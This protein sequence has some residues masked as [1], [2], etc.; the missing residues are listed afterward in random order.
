MKYVNKAFSAIKNFYLPTDK[1]EHHR[2]KLTIARIFLTLLTATLILVATYFAPM[3]KA[4]A[5]NAGASSQVA[6]DKEI[7]IHFSAPVKR[8]EITATITPEVKGEWVWS[9]DLFG[10]KRMYK[11]LV[12]KPIE[13]Y[14]LST[15][16]VVEVKGV[17]RV[18]GVGGARDYATEFQTQ[19]APQISSVGPNDGSV[20]VRPDAKIVINLDLPNTNIVEYT[21]KFEPAFDFTSNYNKEKTTLTLSPKSALVQGQ[22]YTL[23]VSR[24]AIAYDLAA[25][26]VILRGEPETVKTATFTVAMPP[27]VASYSPSGGYIPISTRQMRMAFTHDMDRT[28][29]GQNFVTEPALTGKISWENDKTLIFT[30]TNNLAYATTYRF[31]VKQGAKN[32]SGGFL[33]NDSVASFATIGNAYVTYFSPSN[34]SYGNRVGTAIEVGFDQAVD[35]TSAQ[36]KFSFSGGNGG[37]FA[38]NGNVMV[39]YPAG[40]LAK[41]SSYTISVATGVKSISGLDTNRGF[42]ATFYTEESSVKLAIPLDYQDRALSCE[43]AS[44]KMALN[45]KGAGV[46][47]GSILARLA[48]NSAPRINNVWGNPYA[49][50]VG[51]IDGAQNTTGYGVYWGPIASAGAA[52]RPTQAVVGLTAAQMASELAAGNPIVTWGTAGRAYYDPWYTSSGQKIDAWKGEH[53]RTVIG[54][55]G[56]VWAPRQF[57]VNDPIFGQKYWSTD[58]LLGNMSAFG[59]AGVIVR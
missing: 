47:E 36:S 7:S 23:T 11:T 41:D 5:V 15:K 6:I 19:R 33:P 39:Y 25:Q 50:F 35:H 22:K 13:A 12:F 53:A 58:A 8:D 2:V 29:V 16:Y 30:Y 20:E 48:Y 31:I 21:A 34:G 40:V 54:F 42:S 9:D 45:Y 52:W 57:I 44:L 1:S 32:L 14:K 4:L 55:V 59:Y 56:P 10:T 38:W 51:N 18:V 24:S 37:S 46:S 28:S 49:E 27:G 3:P 17:K 26:K 43:L